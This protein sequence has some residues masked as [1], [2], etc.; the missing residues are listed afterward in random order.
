VLRSVAQRFEPTG[1]GRRE[2]GVD[3]QPQLG[4]PQ[5]RVVVLKR[6]KLQDRRDVVGLQIVVVLEDLVASCTG[7]QEVEHIL[8]PDAKAPDARTPAAY[9]RVDGNPVNRG[10]PSESP[11]LISAVQ[12]RMTGSAGRVG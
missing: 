8:H 9:S 10:R 2:L 7:G 4:A 12:L 3:Q 5:D 6:R 1:Q 11:Y